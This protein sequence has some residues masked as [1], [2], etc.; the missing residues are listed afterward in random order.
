MTILSPK[1][2]FAVA[3]NDLESNVYVESRNEIDGDLKLIHH[4]TPT[5]GILTGMCCFSLE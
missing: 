2:Y 3:D 5:R 1:R 4:Y